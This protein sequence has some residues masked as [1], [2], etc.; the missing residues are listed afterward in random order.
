MRNRRVKMSLAEFHRLPISLVWKQEYING[1]LVQ[2]PRPVLVHATVPVERRNATSPVALRP[3][4]E[5]DERGLQPIFQAAF[6][7]T[8][9]FCDCTR[10]RLA[11]AA[12]EY[13]YRFFHRP[14]HRVLSASMVALAPDSGKPIGAALVLAEDDGWALLD[15]IF[16]APAW[17]RQGVATAMAAAVLNALHGIGGCRTLVS[18]YHLGNEAS[19]GWHHRFGFVD[20]P[21]MRVAQLRLRAAQHEL[22]RLE[23]LGALTPPVQDRLTRERDRWQGEVDR[24]EAALGAGY[25]EEVWPWYKW[26]RK[27]PD[28]DQSEAQSK[29]ISSEASKGLKLD[30]TK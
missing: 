25:Y 28:G 10:Q 18:C 30:Q 29:R 24:L 1:C 14:C 8:A 6:S 11:E 16:I 17:Q 19:A 5:G 3:V 13:L 15:M 20:E 26:K 2:S 27:K 9:E 21:D 12:C 22:H 23:D 7:G 4:I